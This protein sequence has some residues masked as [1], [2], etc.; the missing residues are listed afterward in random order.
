MK[1]QVTGLAVAALLVAWAATA[2][3]Q[4]GQGGYLG[5]NPGTTQQSVIPS[6]P[7]TPP[8][9]PSVAFSRANEMAS[10]MAWC[11]QSP[12]PSHCRGRAPVEDTICRDKADYGACRRAIDPMHNTK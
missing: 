6:A 9:P 4:S 5:V 7:R 12:D 3:A 1:P 10:P 11:S 2:Q 8:P